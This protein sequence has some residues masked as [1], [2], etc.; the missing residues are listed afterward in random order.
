MK[1]QRPLVS[2]GWLGRHGFMTVINQ[3]AKATAQS[4]RRSRNSGMKTQ[5]RTPVKH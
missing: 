2:T 5:S 4:K 1:L 3:K